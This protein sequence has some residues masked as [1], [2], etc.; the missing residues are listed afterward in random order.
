MLKTALT[1][2]KSE[3]RAE[4]YLAVVVGAAG[5]F[6]LAREVWRLKAV[7]SDKN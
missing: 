3:S 5:A 4:T 1:A 7:W 6:L 2:W